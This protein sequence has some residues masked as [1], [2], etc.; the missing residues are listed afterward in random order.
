MRVASRACHYCAPLRKRRASPGV[1]VAGYFFELPRVWMMVAPPLTCA[2][3]PGV[4]ESASGKVCKGVRAHG[5]GEGYA[6]S[7]RARA[8]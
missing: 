7:L 5:R 3:R 2:A 4:G 1:V 8:V 6:P